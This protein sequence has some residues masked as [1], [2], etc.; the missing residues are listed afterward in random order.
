MDFVIETDKERIIAE[1]M[2]NDPACERRR[3]AAFAGMKDKEERRS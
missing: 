1:E 2:K 3:F